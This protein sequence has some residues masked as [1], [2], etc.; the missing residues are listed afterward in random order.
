MARSCGVEIEPFAKLSK[1]E[2]AEIE[3]EARHLAQF[4]ES[5]LDLKFV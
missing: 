4:Y 1:T 5:S 2:R 3:R